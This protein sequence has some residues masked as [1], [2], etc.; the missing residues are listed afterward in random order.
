MLKP[1]RSLGYTLIELLVALSILGIT[2]AVVLV[3]FGSFKGDQTLRN[4]LA[5]LQ[6]L[7]R[8]AQSNATSG[9][10]CNGAG[11]ANWN[12]K[13]LSDKT[14]IILDCQ[15]VSNP[16]PITQ[17][18]VN[19]NANNKGIIVDRINGSQSC[20]PVIV[21][22]AYVTGKVAFLSN[23]CVSGAS[24]VSI[25]LKNT[26]KGTVKTLKINKG[27]TVDVQK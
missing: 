3:N 27:G 16:V 15:T 18:T 13:F 26:K 23:P 11:E 12:I 10:K 8:E 6:S 4:T 21:S 20:I 19:L 7:I 22:F 25:N 17:K 5:E 9:V 14:T 24:S 1:A 2:G